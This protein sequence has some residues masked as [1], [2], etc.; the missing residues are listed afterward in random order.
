MRSKTKD[1]YPNTYDCSV[2]GNVLFGED[3][4]KAALREL[5]EELGIKNVKIMPLIHFRLIY[6][7]TDY[8]ICKLFRCVYDGKIKPNEEVSKVK[9]FEIT[10]LKKIMEKSE[11]LTPYFL[12]ILRWY[13]KM[14]NKL[15]IFRI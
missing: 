15:Y 2:S 14:K 9:F 13:F 10:E 12:E 8:H 7:S 3:Y 1:K 5:E 6:S 4:E 11:M